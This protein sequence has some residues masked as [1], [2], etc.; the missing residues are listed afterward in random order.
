MGAICNVQYM[1]LYTGSQDGMRTS[2]IVCYII[3]TTI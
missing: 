3:Y 2:E 1:E